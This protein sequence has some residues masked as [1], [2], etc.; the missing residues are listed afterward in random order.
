MS[1]FI[2][3]IKVYVIEYQS[4]EDI[5]EN[6]N[7]GKT[8][9][10]G[11]ELAGINNQYF[12]VINER[13]LDICLDIISDDILE[14]RKSNDVILP[15]L[16]FSAHGNETGLGLSNGDFLDWNDLR[17]KIDRVN[18]IIGKFKLDGIT[19]EFSYLHLCFSVCKG[20]YSKNIQ[21]KLEEN[22]YFF[23]VGPIDAVNWS[24]SLIAF[25]TF[26]HH[27]F[28][29]KSKALI[30]VKNMNTAAGLNDIFKISSGYGGSFYI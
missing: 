21:G 6:R 22:K 17:V 19:V 15:F 3:H 23:T 5:L 28:H 13:I 16:H 18:S 9:S 2:K 8:L 4:D 26:Y 25:M 20:F 29:G 12:Q 10:S 1:K 7:E 14:L 27:I 11:L 30:A 24:D